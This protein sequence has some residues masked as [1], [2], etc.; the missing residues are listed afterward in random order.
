MEGKEQR[1]RERETYHLHPDELVDAWAEEMRQ[2]FIHNQT[3]EAKSQG[4]KNLNN[5]L[6]H[7]LVHC[8]K[9]T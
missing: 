3:V 7:H 2:K 9:L 8:F 1:A 6:T 4:L 5:L